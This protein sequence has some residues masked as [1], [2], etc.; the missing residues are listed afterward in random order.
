MRIAKL[1][2]PS[3]SV[4]ELRSS[5]NKSVSVCI[6]SQSQCVNYTL[7]GALIVILVC[8]FLFHIFYLHTKYEAFKVKDLEKA[9]FL[10][11]YVFLILNLV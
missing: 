4:L 1:H 11:A 7:L 8:S 3:A 6:H 2:K 5:L 9:I 10:C